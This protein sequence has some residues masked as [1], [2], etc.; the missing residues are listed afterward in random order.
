MIKLCGASRVLQNFEV[1]LHD[2]N[3]RESDFMT[4][5]GDAGKLLENLF[6]VNCDDVPTT[7]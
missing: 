6:R 2:E 1:S 5:P 4:S 7:L 3:D